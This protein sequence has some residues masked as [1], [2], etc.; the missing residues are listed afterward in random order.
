MDTQKDLLGKEIVKN[1]EALETI[2]ERDTTIQDQKNKYDQLQGDYQANIQENQKQMEELRTNL[3]N[4]QEELV[5]QLAA[6]EKEIATIETEKQDLVLENNRLMSQMR[7]RMTGGAPSPS[8]EATPGIG[9]DLANNPPAMT[10]EGDQSPVFEGFQ[11]FKQHTRVLG[12]SPKNKMLVLHIGAQQGLKPT[13]KL[14]LERN[15]SA[16]AR[17]GI[18]KIDHQPGVSFFTVLQS[19]ESEEWQTIAAFQR[20]DAVTILE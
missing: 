6:K 16:L 12:F 11:A 14:R 20:G 3:K 19:P 17:L 7:Q 13:M 2:A 5:G 4:K 8:G 10:G 15:G 9:P 18:V 1:E